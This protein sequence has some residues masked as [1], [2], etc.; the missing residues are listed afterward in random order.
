M[1]IKYFLL[2]SLLFPF[3][4][5]GQN[6]FEGVIVN[7]AT[8]VP[9]PYASIFLIKEKVGFNAD[10]NGLFKLEITNKEVDDSLIVT[11]IGYAPLKFPVQK[12]DKLWSAN[13]KIELTEL[14]HNL[15]EVLILNNNFKNSIMLNE[16]EKFSGRYY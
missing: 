3:I 1:K 12:A 16:F 11:C 8:K 6:K 10:E 5:N 9:I 2:F 13:A 15:K 4:S 7:K 14:V